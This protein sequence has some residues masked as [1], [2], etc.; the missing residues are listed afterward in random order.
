MP[1]TAAEQLVVWSVRMDDEEQETAILVMVCRG[2]PTPH[3]VNWMDAAK[4]SSVVRQL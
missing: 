3:P 4:S 1:V 2:V